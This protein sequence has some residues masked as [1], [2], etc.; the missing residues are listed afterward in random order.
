MERLRSRNVLVLE[1]ESIIAL[2]LSVAIED[3]G[4]RVFCAADCAA[5]LGILDV[6]EVDAAVLDVN[7]GGETCERVARRLRKRSIPFLLHTGDLRAANELVMRL[8]APVAPKPARQGEIEARLARL[9]G[10]ARDVPQ[11]A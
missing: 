2:E 3:Q 10:P 5:A 6:E 8:G 7:L 1:D 9:L 11:P 4:A